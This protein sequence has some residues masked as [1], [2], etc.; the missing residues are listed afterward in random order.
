MSPVRAIRFF[1]IQ[2]TIVLLLEMAL[3]LGI[4][5]SRIRG[6][7]FIVTGD[8]KTVEVRRRKGKKD[9]ADPKRAAKAVEA[10]LEELWQQ[11]IKYRLTNNWE[12]ASMRRN[13]DRGRYTVGHYMKNWRCV[14]T[15]QC[16]GT[17]AGV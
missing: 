4:L 14:Q 3:S 6:W 9:T 2:W 7:L 16:S 11:A 15:L 13:I 12:L 17:H 10:E 1:R 5:R 8:G